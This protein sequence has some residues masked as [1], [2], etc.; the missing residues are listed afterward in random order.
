M[1]ALKRDEILAGLIP[2]PISVAKPQI[3]RII[4]LD[5]NIGVGKTTLLDHI[6]KRF[7]EV[8]I[9]KEPVDV[10]THLKDEQGSSLLELFYK[11]KRRYAFT[12]QQAAM[13]SR[14]LLLQKAV[15]EAKPGSLILT[16]RSVLTDRHVFAEM[17]YT[18]GDL[19]KLEK[20][21]YDQ[22][23]NAFAAQL[24]IAGIVYITT[25]VDTAFDR[26]QTRAREGESIIS[27]EYLKA[28][29]WQHQV[30]LTNTTGPKLEISTETGTDL[31]GTLA[32]LQ[33][34]FAAT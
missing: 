21:L 10:W 12:F 20:D 14:L 1:P 25:S 6:Q 31:E 29:D 19:S 22:W 7:P 3:T 5:G 11:D 27:K 32:A 24:P 15:A 16:E 34:F 2:K 23:Y 8:I 17:L 4:S 9:V 30:W 26:I 13:L 28:L 18:S 33:I